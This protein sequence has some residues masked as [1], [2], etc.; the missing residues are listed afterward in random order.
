M[1]SGNHKNNLSVS[2][3]SSEFTKNNIE[4]YDEEE[5]SHFDF[6]VKEYKL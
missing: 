5:T 1:V 2:E 4:S 3:D 6:Y